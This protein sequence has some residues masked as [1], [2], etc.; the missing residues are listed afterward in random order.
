M[1]RR[2]RFTIRLIALGFAVVGLSAAPAQAKVDEGL[3][4]H[5]AGQGQQRIIS[6]DDRVDRVTPGPSN[7][8]VYPTTTRILSADDL[9]NR[10]TPAPSQPTVVSS[11]DGFEWGT[12]IGL[13]GIVLVL[14][15]LGMYLIVHQSQKGKFAS[16]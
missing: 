8:V 16:A 15:A 14:G 6:A 9:T 1:K 7:V 4:Y 3:G 11:N 12:T 2:K 5:W 13:S 10:V